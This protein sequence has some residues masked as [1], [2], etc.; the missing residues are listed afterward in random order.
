MVV[1]IED[2][3]LVKAK[4]RKDAAVFVRKHDFANFA[5]KRRHEAGLVLQRALLCE[6]TVQSALCRQHINILT[7]IC[8]ANYRSL[9]NLHLLDELKLFL[10]HLT[11]TAVLT[12]YKDTAEVAINRVDSS[13][14]RSG[15]GSAPLEP[16][17]LKT[18]F[19]NVARAS[20]TVQK[21]VI[22]IYSYAV[23]VPFDLA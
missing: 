17:R 3:Y 21:L 12:A 20:T 19:K 6:Y 8:Q 13:L 7:R 16:A 5:V 11:Q 23:Y 4:T 22:L 2:F 9:A 15:N 10:I 14:E 18:N 1:Y